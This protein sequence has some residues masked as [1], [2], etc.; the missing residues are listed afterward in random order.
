MVRDE[1]RAYNGQTGSMEMTFRSWLKKQRKRIGPVGDLARDTF[2]DDGIPL[3]RRMTKKTLLAHM[4]Q[5]YNPCD[6]AL[7][8]LDEAYSEFQSE[9]AVC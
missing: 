9:K 6:G 8:A 3:P 5:H 7:S 2:T 1:A 4:E